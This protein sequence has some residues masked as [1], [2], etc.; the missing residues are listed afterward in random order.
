MDSN[1]ILGLIGGGL[2]SYILP[3]ISPKIDKLFIFIGHL[4][5]KIAPSKIKG[6]FRKKRLVKL[7]LIRKLRYNQDA[8]MFQ[9]IKA[10]SYFILFWG[11]IALYSVLFV[12]SP[13]L[14]FVNQRASLFFFLI[15]PIYIFEWFW[16]KETKKA[17]K[18]IKNRG[19]L[20][21]T[22]MSLLK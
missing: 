19:Y 6:Y 4:L 7:R 20:R 21:I 8:V 17:Q 12:M 11:V 3:K 1:L 5:F 13:L 10:H 16:L 22:H 18:L 2:V 9:T 15:S 14:E